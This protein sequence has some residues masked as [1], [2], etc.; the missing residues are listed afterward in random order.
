MLT[1]A[2]DLRDRRTG[3]RPRP[4]RVVDHLASQGS[5]TYDRRS[6]ML[7]A[8][9]AGSNTDHRSSP[10]SGDHLTR[11]EVISS[12]G[13]F[14]VSVT[15][16]GHLVYVLNALDGGSIQGYYR[17]GHRLREIPRWHRA[18]GL[19]VGEPQFTHTPGQVT[20]TPNGSKLVV[21]TKA[22]GQQRRRV[23]A[24][25]CSGVRRR[26]RS[27]A[28][29]DR[30]YPSPVTFD[31]AG[32]LLRHLGRSPTRLRPSRSRPS[33]ILDPVR[34]RWL[35]DKRRPAG[36]CATA[37]IPLRIERWKRQPVRRLGRRRTARSALLGTTAT[38]A[39]TVDAAASHRRAVHLRADGCG[40]HRRREF[41]ANADG[42]LT[43]IGS[44]TVPG[45]VGGEGIVAL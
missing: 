14:P 20:F 19:P 29:W 18:L 39:G 10:C 2:G 5:L 25:V 22:G 38:D 33:G 36:S 37:C 44:V 17:L 7:Y 9:N 12:G 43:A 3:R 30:T 34:R 4:V 16:H 24:W 21:T 23:Q 40:W 45:A 6:R 15:T 13:S 42:S 11:T 28:S 41:R 26:H 27:S 8:V 32:R 1:Q 35:P 31:R